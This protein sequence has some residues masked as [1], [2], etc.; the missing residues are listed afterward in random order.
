VLRARRRSR[1]GGREGDGIA[2]ESDRVGIESRGLLE[3]SF[4]GREK[5][6]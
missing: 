4:L 6:R 3:K 1:G 5:V 2:K